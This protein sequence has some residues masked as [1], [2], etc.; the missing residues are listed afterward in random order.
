MK[1]GVPDE[2]ADRGYLSI[3]VSQPGYGGS[4]GPADFCGPF[5]QHAVEAVLEKVRADGLVRDNRI[6]LEGVSRGAM[7]AG[8]TAV[9][10]PSIQGIV[11]IS[12]V[13][14]LTEYAKRANNA[15]SRSVVASIQ[16]ETGGSPDAL[17]SRSL[18]YYAQD[19]RANALILNG[20]QDDRTDPEQALRLAA[21]INEHR[22]Q[23]KAIVYPQYGHQIPVE[24]RNK[25]IEPF[26]E[27]TL[28]R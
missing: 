2:Y 1:W 11:L 13:Y 15:T 21:A 19:V 17:K 3:A 18:L 8:L 22:G 10:D 28:G 4:T 25:D 24:V 12:G 20:G 5:T 23:A 27:K 9:H 6:L 7:V 16:A 26:I 14:D